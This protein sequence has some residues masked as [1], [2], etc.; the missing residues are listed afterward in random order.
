MGDTPKRMRLL[1]EEQKATIRAKALERYYANREH[2]IERNRA[3]KVQNRDRVKARA[4]AYHAEN[5]DR[6]NAAAKVWKTKNPD[7][8]ISQRKNY[9]ESNRERLRE[10]YR[11]WRAANPEAAKQATIAWRINNP[12][13]VRGAHAARRARKKNARVEKFLPVEVFERDGWTCYLCLRP[14]DK[15][16][17]YPHRLAAVLDHV[18]PLADGG[19]HSKSNTAC[20]HNVCNAKKNAKPWHETAEIMR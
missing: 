1:T 10:T 14:V 2:A 11:E 20:A 4:A 12:D 6:Q 5:K 13:A 8:V 16:V 3:W 7:K 9:C 18:V 15:D 19:E 17:K